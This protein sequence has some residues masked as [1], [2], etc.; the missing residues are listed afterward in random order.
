MRTSKCR[1][2]SPSRTT[3]PPATGEPR[4]SRR[5]NSDYVEAFERFMEAQAM[6]ENTRKTYLNFIRR[7]AEFFGPKSFLDARRF[8][9]S[10]FRAFLYRQR[11]SDGSMASAVFALRKFYDF[12]EMGEVMRGSPAR[13]LA[14]RKVPKRLPRDIPEDGI[15]KLLAAARSPRDLALLEFLYATGCRKAEVAN[16]NVED[17]CLPA[18]SATVRNGKGGKDRVVLF[19]RPAAGALEAYLGKRDR[20]PLFLSEPAIQKGAVSR[21]RWGTWRGYWREKNGAGRLV[22]RSIRLGD[23]ELPN[24]ER[25]QKAL[26]AFL[27]APSVAPQSPREKRRLGEKNVWRIVVETAMR[28]GLGHVTT[29]QLRHSF[30]THCIDHG[31]DIRYLQELLGHTS[32]V[33]TQKYLH[34]SPAKLLDVHRKFFLEVGP[35]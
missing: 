26:E 13:M 12:L 35:K 15:K 16:M 3:Q 24:R 11:F 32:L 20:G 5:P 18:R 28:A 30:A 19:G 21:D 2:G 22:M 6:P 8:D 7:L 34:S 9:L 25:A 4:L 10:E 29:H 14:T 23:Y 1:R 33:A 31:M 17:V 27:A